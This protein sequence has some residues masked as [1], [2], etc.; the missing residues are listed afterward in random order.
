VCVCVCVCVLC[1]C[2]CVCVCVACVE[3]DADVLY[4][5]RSRGVQVRT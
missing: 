1:V 2:V 3:Y 4:G 5:A